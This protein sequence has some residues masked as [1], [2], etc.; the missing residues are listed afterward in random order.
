MTQQ[1]KLELFVEKK[2][3]TLSL[4]VYYLSN[5]FS[6]FIKYNVFP[7]RRQWWRTP[8]L[9]PRKSHGWRSLVGC[10]SW[11]RKESD[12][13]ERLHFSL[14]T[15]HFHALEKEMATHSSI[16]AWKIPWTEDPGRLQFMGSQRV[17]HDWATSLHF[18]PWGWSWSL[19][20]IQCH[21]PPSIVLQAFWRIGV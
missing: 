18:T 14:F 4:N 16:L 20:P 3:R 7:R 2:N 13:T 17:G 21:K 1:W 8:V 12:M 15:F 10:S 11:G 19:P 5:R 6:K 9:L